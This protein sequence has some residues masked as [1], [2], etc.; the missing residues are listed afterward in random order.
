[1]TVKVPLPSRP[2][3]TRNDLAGGS[4]VSTE[5]VLSSRPI[6]LP[7][8]REEPLVSVLI[9]SYN[10]ER[11]I[12]R[13]IESVL[14]QSYLRVEV[15]V[16]D[17]GSTDDSVQVIQRY[18]E[19]DPRVTLIRQANAGHTVAYSEAYRHCH[20]DILCLLDSDDLFAPHKVESIVECFRNRSGVGFVIH[21]LIMIDAEERY[22]QPL[23]ML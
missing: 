6:E 13:A 9:A 2:A 18:V 1:M 15:V 3:D 5:P 16:C 4:I 19:R 12:G 8:L 17:D 14:N 7:A 20:G 23:T 11:Y 10:Y 21:P 22:I